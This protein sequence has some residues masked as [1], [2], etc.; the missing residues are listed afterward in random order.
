MKKLLIVEDEQYL[1]DMYK[2]KFEH[3]GY[4]VRVAYDGKEGLALAR[5][6]A[7]DLILLDIVMPVMNGY[8]MLHELRRDE[9]LKGIKTYILSNLGQADEI[10]EALDDGADGYLI[11]ANLT[12]DQLLE[13]VRKAIGE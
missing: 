9:A 10:K 1:A 7:P 13:E 11:K 4:S 5:Q 2:M 3:A 6:E 8:R 12:P